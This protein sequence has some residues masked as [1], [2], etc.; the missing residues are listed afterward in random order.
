MIAPVMG[1]TLIGT[2]V[3]PSTD[4]IPRRV[5]VL[6]ASREAFHII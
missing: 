2:G 3:I 5:A 4:D 1:S 6:F